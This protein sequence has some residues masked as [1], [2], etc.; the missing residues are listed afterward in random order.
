MTSPAEHSSFLRQF[1]R[2]FWVNPVQ[3]AGRPAP[4][5]AGV[6][7]VTAYGMIVTDLGELLGVLT[8]T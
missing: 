3:A 4:M 7:A 5:P 1:W 2:W 6:Q 8:Y